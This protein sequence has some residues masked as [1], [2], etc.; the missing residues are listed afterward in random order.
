MAGDTTDGCLPSKMVPSQSSQEMD[1]VSQQD[2]DHQHLDCSQGGNSQ[3]Q[4][5]LSQ[6]Q[7]A[8]QPLEFSQESLAQV[9]SQGP[10]DGV[11]G[12]LFPY[13]GTFP[14][15][16]LTEERFRVGRASSCDYSIRESDMG[17]MRWLTTVSKVQCEIYRNN[18]DV[19]LTD[20]SSNGTWVNG[21]KVGRGTTIPLEHNATI[22]FSY[23]VK[24]VFVFMSSDVVEESFPEALTSKYTV[25][26]LL[27]TGVSGQVRLG[28]RARDLYK[29]AIKMIRKKVNGTFSSQ[30]YS[31]EQVN[32]EVEILRS[33]KH[34]CVIN[35]VDVIDTTDYLFIILE[36]AEGGELFDKIIEK[37]KLDESAAKI[38]FFQIASAIEYLHSKKICHRDLKPENILLCSVDDRNPLVKITDMGLSKLLVDQTRLKTFCGTPQYIAPEVLKQGELNGGE[39]TFRER[40]YSVKVDCWGLG[41]VLYILLS[42]SPP[43]SEDRKIGMKLRE[44]ILN[45]NYVFY[46]KLFGNI[47]EEAQDLIRK[48][49]KVD[50]NERISSSEILQHSWLQG[51]IIEDKARE[52]GLTY[53]AK[54][55]K[56]LAE[57]ADMDSTEQKRIKADSPVFKQ[58]LV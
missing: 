25:S 26:K 20:C 57:E 5:A 3:S 42:G 35:L 55:R 12:Q 46:P 34:P 44:Q 49:L 54:A 52:L 8:T 41:V 36:L 37:S 4:P 51:K 38:Y 7:P 53:Q 29:V 40:A 43:F 14:R 30:A 45:A 31:Q 28:F 24:K 22:C 47:S 17:G 1:T 19:F 9:A 16:K 56:R 21:T 50:P 6:S 48:L 39:L 32:N 33:V 10:E 15:I 13:S 27:G 23:P 58:P 2:V 18:A 11:W